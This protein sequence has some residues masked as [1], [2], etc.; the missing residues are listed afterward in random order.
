MISG[1]CSGRPRWVGNNAL[2]EGGAWA[3][4]RRNFA[5]C[6]GPVERH[7]LTPPQRR[8]LERR[9]PELYRSCARCSET[10]AYRRGA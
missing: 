10:G 9:R 7:Q 8:G 5:E 4:R 3:A 2:D 6:E 1:E